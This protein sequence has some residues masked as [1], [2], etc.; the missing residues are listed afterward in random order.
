LIEAII[1]PELIVV[2][3]IKIR[4]SKKDLYESVVAVKNALEKRDVISFFYELIF[5]RAHALNTMQ[6]LVV[7]LAGGAVGS[8][9]GDR[10]F[11]LNR[12]VGAG[13]G[14][15]AVYLVTELIQSNREGDVTCSASGDYQIRSKGR[16]GLLMAT[17][18]YTTVSEP[19]L[20][21]MGLPT[22]CTD[23]RAAQVQAAL[24]SGQIGA[25]DSGAL[26]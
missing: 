24:S 1:S 3:G 8:M 22:T 2:N 26:Y 11:G 7:A 20:T 17:A 13:I 14:V 25:P 21:A 23:S 6:G 5:P 16:N 10:F 18:E 19:T 4:R 9:A 15:G 12:W